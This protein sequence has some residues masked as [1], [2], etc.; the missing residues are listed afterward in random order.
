M[1]YTVGDH[2][3]NGNAIFPGDLQYEIFK[4]SV[5]G[6][7][8]DTTNPKAMPTTPASCFSSDQ[9]VTTTSGSGG[10]PNP[11]QDSPGGGSATSTTTP[12][13]IDTTNTSSPVLGGTADKTIGLGAPM[14]LLLVLMT[15]A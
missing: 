13:G 8:P 15:N 10:D 2:A 7:D 6:V 3:R 4:N 1:N 9:T 11:S 5:G 14:L 12:S